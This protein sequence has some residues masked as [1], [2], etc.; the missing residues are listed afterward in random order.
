MRKFVVTVALAAFAALFT[1]SNA[2]AA[3]QLRYS[4]NGGAFVPVTGSA[5]FIQT[6]VGGLNIGAT[7]TNDTSSNITHIDL[8]VDGTVS[9]GL[10]SLIVQAS[11]TDINTAPAP[12]VLAYTMQGTAPGTVTERADVSTGNGLFDPATPAG[13][14]TGNQNPDASMN[15]VGALVVNGGNTYSAT[16]TNSFAF[17]GTGV[18]SSDNGVTITPTPAPAG[19]LLVLSGTPVLGLGYWL[20]R[21]ARA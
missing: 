2:E 3:F 7:A 14:T 1:G 21:K 5:T 8:A 20:R 15:L 12:Q 11:L 18:V 16:L 9:A 19:L 17:T 13:N 4:I 10:T 6:Q